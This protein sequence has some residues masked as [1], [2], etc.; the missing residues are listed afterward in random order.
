MAQQS[1]MVNLIRRLDRAAPTNV[2]TSSFP[3]IA[4]TV[5]DPLTLRATTPR[6]VVDLT[7]FGT[8]A[9]YTGG[10]APKSI[11]GLPIGLGAANDAFDMKVVGWRQIGAG[12]DKN[13]LWLP[14]TIASLTCTVGAMTGIAGTP[15]LNT[16]L[17]CD[18]IV[19]KS[20]TGLGTSCWVRPS[21]DATPAA[22]YRGS[23]LLWSPADDSIAA[24]A[25]P[26]LGCQR[27][28]FIF[29]QVTN[30]PTMNVLFALAGDLWD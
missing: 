16:E 24:F 28:E 9:Q 23:L 11:I 30:T 19:P 13:Q 18:T 6:A 1:E 26:T 22:T 7:S 21:I 4:P 27:V 12:E 25:V 2:N 10:A 5:I 15:V 8:L 17:F 20:A 3:T 29:D 14:T